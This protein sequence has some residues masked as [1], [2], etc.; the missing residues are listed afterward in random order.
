MSNYLPSC[1]NQP[2]FSV[3]KWFGSQNALLTRAVGRFQ[4]L[5]GHTLSRVQIM[6][7]KLVGTSNKSSKYWVGK[8][9]C[10]HPVPTALHRVS[11]WKEALHRHCYMTTTAAAARG[12]AA[13][14]T[15][16]DGTVIIITRQCWCLLL[17]WHSSTAAASMAVHSVAHRSRWLLARVS[18]RCRQES[19][20]HLRRGNTLSSLR[21]FT[22]RPATIAAYNCPSLP[23]LPYT[24]S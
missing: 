17:L 12:A 8:C 20:K 6:T 21:C 18:N 13:V 7:M 2:N 1:N 9:P 15:Q 22:P 24:R 19:T 23:P 14:G 11:Q 4:I 10:A 5:G 3:W 16:L